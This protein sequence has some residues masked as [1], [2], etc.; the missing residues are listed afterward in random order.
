MDGVAPGFIRNPARPD[1]PVD[2]PSIHQEEEQADP[3]AQGGVRP[4]AGMLQVVFE[5]HPGIPERLGRE[6]FEVLDVL[7]APIMS[8]SAGP[9]PR[10]LKDG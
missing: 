6:G 4:V 3:A 9:S 2:D 7:M 5:G 8:Q 1:G 10:K